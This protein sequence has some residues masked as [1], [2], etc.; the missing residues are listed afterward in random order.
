MKADEKEI[1]VKD[2]VLRIRGGDQA[3]FNELLALYAPLVQA[4][5]ARHGEALGDF[6]REDLRQV[7]WLALYRASFSFDLEQ[8]E[9]SFG[10]FAKICIANALSTQ[11]RAIRRRT[12]EVP[13]ADEVFVGINGEDG[14]PAGRVREEEDIQLLRSRIRAL[15]S[16]L[17]NRVW[18]LYTA[19]FSAKEIG[20]RLGRE[21]RSIENA[22]YRIRQ[23]LREAL[24]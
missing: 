10:L 9:V 14:D 16:P 23:K 13:V 5:V 22:V 4:E 7:A 24:G 3:A 2:L 12:V 11:L 15:L 8:T 20:A 21:P 1:V 18:A 6:D 17:E 19:G